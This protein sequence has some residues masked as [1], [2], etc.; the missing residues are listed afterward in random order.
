VGRLVAQDH[1]PDLF[2]CTTCQCR[3]AEPVA[4]GDI[5]DGLRLYRAVEARLAAMREPAP[6]RLHAIS[7]FAN[8]ERGCSAAIAAPG[9]WSYLMGGLD[10]GLAGDLLTYAEA[11]R[12]SASGV[13]LPS[14]RPAALRDAVIARFPA[15]FAEAGGERPAKEA[16]E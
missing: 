10:A 14:R 5:A 16:A 15:H 4:D 11:Y 3:G 12:R 8:C 7:C 1:L 6:V 13:L 2:I 9:K